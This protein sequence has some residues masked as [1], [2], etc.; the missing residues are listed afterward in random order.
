MHAAGMLDTIKVDAYGDRMPLKG[1]ASV[2]VKDAQ[3]LSVSVF[4]PSVSPRLQI[5]VCEGKAVGLL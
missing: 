1:V 3:S 4:D 5:K 2:T